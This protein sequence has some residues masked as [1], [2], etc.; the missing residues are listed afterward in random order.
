MQWWLFLVSGPNICTHKL[1]FIL[2]SAPAV[3]SWVFCWDLDSFWHSA[4]PCWPWSLA[5]WLPSDLE[6]CWHRNWLFHFWPSA[7]LL[8]NHNWYPNYSEAVFS[9]KIDFEK[10]KFLCVPIMTGLDF[11]EKTFSSTR[12][13]WSLYKT[14]CQLVSAIYEQV[15]YFD[16][17]VQTL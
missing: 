5:H 13:L 8:T 16:Y 6:T 11:S 4:N 3:T 15:S 1:V 12:P 10:V 14:S 17:S 2:A 9:H 7:G